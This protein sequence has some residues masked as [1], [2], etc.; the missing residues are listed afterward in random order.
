MGLLTQ[1]ARDYYAGSQ[2]FTGTGAA[3]NF[4]IDLQPL[5]TVE[6]DFIVLIDNAQI[7]DTLYSYASPTLTFNTAP[8]LNA[9]IEVKL[10][11]KKYGDYRFVGLS[12]LVSNFMIEYVGPG[13]LI[14]GAQRRDVIHHIKRSIQQFSY[15]IGV[16]ERVQEIECPPSLAI[17]MPQDYVNWVK[18]SFVDAA[19][20]EHPIPEG[21]ITS[22]PTQAILQDSD[23]NYLFDGADALLESE[24]V[25]LE[26]FK[27]VT[28]SEVSDTTDIDMGLIYDAGSRY[29]GDPEHMN[30]NGMF[31]INEDEGVFNFSSNLAG[32][33]ITIKY[34][35]D[36]LANDAD[37]RVSK[38]AEEA[39][40]KDV[41]FRLLTRASNVQ[42]YL[43][44]RLKRERRAE[45]RN[46]KIRLG[47]FRIANIVHVLKN[48]SKTIK[49]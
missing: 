4:T 35:S 22:S 32:A 8:A 37:M 15:D 29:G 25:T 31:T 38:L 2:L 43:V 5:P 23:G 13:K 45:M 12:D 40:Y 27:T 17:P 28:A 30:V 3:V 11:G 46:A 21:R 39:I 19:G 24:S 33:L 44:N 20:I 49:H 10:V 41:A 36:G 34:I 26:R 7:A 16:A 42:E 18:I 47:R 6:A 1:T 48:H 14:G 9:T